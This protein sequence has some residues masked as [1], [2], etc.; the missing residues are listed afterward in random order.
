[1]GYNNYKPLITLH[2]LLF[3]L[4]PRSNDFA[5]TLPW[6]DELS[7]GDA[8][9]TL[10]FLFLEERLES[11]LALF[12]TLLTPI[13]TLKKSTEKRNI[14]LWHKSLEILSLSIKQVTLNRGFNS[15]NAYKWGI[16]I[17]MPPSPL[18]KTG[19]KRDKISTCRSTHRIV[20]VFIAWHHLWLLCQQIL[21]QPDI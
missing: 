5:L 11:V 7:A 9:F 17:D 8:F 14:Q 2:I 1:M 15:Y 21:W 3:H 19:D 13:T 6:L 12:F 18:S 16:A 20:S 4:P 10:G